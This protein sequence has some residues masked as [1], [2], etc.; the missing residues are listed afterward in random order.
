MEPP[1]SFPLHSQCIT[2]ATTVH[3]KLECG[4]RVV[5]IHGTSFTT[6]SM[7]RKHMNSVLGD[8]V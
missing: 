7:M 6:T 8:Q 4:G 5:T 1:L 2:V 3:S